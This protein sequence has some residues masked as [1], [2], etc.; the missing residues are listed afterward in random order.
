MYRTHTCGEL[1]MKYIGQDVI[2]MRLGSEIEGSW[3]NDIC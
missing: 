1:N 3:R 2:I